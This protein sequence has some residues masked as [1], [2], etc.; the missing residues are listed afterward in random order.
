MA[1]YNELEQRIKELKSRTGKGSI[2]PRETFDLMDELLSKTKGVDMTAQPLVVVKSYDTLALANADRNPINPA[3]NKPLALGQLISITADG[4]NNAVYRLAALAADGS[5]TWEKQAELG[6]MTNYAKQTDLVQLAGETHVK[7]GIFTRDSKLTNIDA[8]GILNVKAAYDWR[9]IT[10]KPLFLWWLTNGSVA[11]NLNRTIYIAYKNSDG[12]FSAANIVASFIA[13]KITASNI[14]DVKLTMR[15]NSG[16]ELTMTIDWSKVTAKS[17]YFLSTDSEL[18][19]S[20]LMKRF[21]VK[22]DNFQIFGKHITSDARKYMVN[23]YGD[24]FSPVFLGK[25]DF[26]WTNGKAYNNG[27]LVDSALFSMSAAK[28]VTPG[29]KIVS[30]RVSSATYSHV[31]I[32]DN[33]AVVSAFGTGGTAWSDKLAEFTVPAEATGVIFCWYNN[34]AAWLNF[35]ADIGNSA[36]VSGNNLS[37]TDGFAWLTGQYAPQAGAYS[38][39]DKMDIKSLFVKVTAQTAV[40][41]GAMCFDAHGAPLGTVPCYNSTLGTMVD[42]RLLNGTKSVSFTYPTANK[43]TFSYQFVRGVL[44]NISSEGL[45]LITAEKGTLITKQLLQSGMDITLKSLHGLTFGDSITWYDGKN[46]TSTHSESGQVAKG[47]QSWMREL[48]GCTISNMGENGWTM[49]MIYGKVLTTNFSG[50]DFVTITSGANDA[51]NGVAMGTVEQ[52]GGTFDTATYAG[53]MQASIEHILSVNK[54][55]KIILLTPIK[56]WYNDPGNYTEIPEIIQN[57]IKELGALYSIIVVD[58]YNNSGI[59]KLNRDIYIGDIQP[60]PYWLHPTNA[61]YERMGRLISKTI[62]SII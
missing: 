57:I 37:W 1:T 14:E 39:T 24:Y 23:G 10:D 44:F 2:S 25:N 62:M 59:N 28:P 42:I 47:Y 17:T 60:A 18:D 34:E 29:S 26:T 31:F 30:V 16:V 5:P 20:E 22:D 55:M 33:G 27:V 58:M 53:S 35:K 46:F 13:D 43:A 3:T 11:H 32:D 41:I 6:D 48:I 54:E 49:P 40:S 56:G 45:W 38:Y 9:H 4:A 50:V 8:P 36:V 52:I 7:N 12:T 15:N 51:K 61:G 19:V 21:D